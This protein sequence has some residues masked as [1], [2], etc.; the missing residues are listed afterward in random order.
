MKIYESLRRETLFL[1][2]TLFRTS[3][4]PWIISHYYSS[5]GVKSCWF[6]FKHKSVSV[7]SFWLVFFRKLNSV[8]TI[9]KLLSHVLRNFGCD[10]RPLKWVKMRKEI[11]VTS[12]N[13]HMTQFES[14]SVHV[15][16]KNL[17][18]FIAYMCVYGRMLKYFLNI[19]Y[20]RNF[21]CTFAYRANMCDVHILIFAYVFLFIFCPILFFRFMYDFYCSNIY[22]FENMG[23]IILKRI[24][25]QINIRGKCFLNYSSVQ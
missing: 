19:M 8:L 11:K 2:L 25:V 23:C 1:V 16:N 10:L 15:T 17:F 5:G 6:V 21:K 14:V 24:K 7:K 20:R 4:S 22:L 13:I 9:Q 12:I 18:L 3:L